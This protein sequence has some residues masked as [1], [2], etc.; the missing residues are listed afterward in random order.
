M[1]E[2]RHQVQHKRIPTLTLKLLLPYRYTN[3]YVSEGLVVDP[4]LHGAAIVVDVL[5]GGH[6]WGGGVV[7]VF[8]PQEEVEMQATPALLFKPVPVVRHRAEHA[9]LA[10]DDPCG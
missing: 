6:S 2:G 8:H 1:E 4:L 9:V 7:G 5:L 3:E 10:L